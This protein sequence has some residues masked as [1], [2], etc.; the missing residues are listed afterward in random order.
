MTL[1]LYRPYAVLPAVR[2]TTRRAHC[3]PPLVLLPTVFTATH[4]SCRYPPCSECV[5]ATVCATVAVCAASAIT[6]LWILA[7]CVK[8]LACLTMYIHTNTV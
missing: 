3:Y 8:S 2:I 6:L 1:L 7:R 4:S 5:N